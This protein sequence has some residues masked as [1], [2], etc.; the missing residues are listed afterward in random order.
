[1]TTGIGSIGEKAGAR[2]ASTN[3][4]P[5]NQRIGEG[6][7]V[8]ISDGAYALVEKN[9]FDFNRHAIAA[10]GAFGTGYFFYR[11]FV[12]SGGGQHEVIFGIDTQTHQIDMHGQQDCWGADGYC[13]VA[14]EYYGYPVQRDHLFYGDCAQA[15]WHTHPAHGCGVQHVSAYGDVWGSLVD[16]GA[17]QQTDGQDGIIQWGNTF[18]APLDVEVA[19]ACDFDVDGVN[20]YFL[21]TGAVWFVSGPVYQGFRYLRGR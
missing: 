1:M 15:T 9:T 21:A 11:N 6:Y 13:G 19:S 14:G 5:H 2:C 17:M 10:D 7:G 20:D 16:S 8:E 18:N 3:Y 4:L 12:G